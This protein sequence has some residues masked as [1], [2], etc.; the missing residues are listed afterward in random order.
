M[1]GGGY[2]NRLLWCFVV[3]VVV[4]RR[5]DYETELL[6][7]AEGGGEKRN[8][9]G[10]MPANDRPPPKTKL[11]SLEALKDGTGMFAAAVGEFH[12]HEPLRH[13]VRT[14]GTQG[15]SALTEQRCVRPEIEVDVIRLGLLPRHVCCGVGQARFERLFSDVS[16]RYAARRKRQW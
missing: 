13:T 3:V 11:Y 10:G 1:K 6:W 4:G 12:L 2:T 16:F 8:E 5:I 15:H 9:R 7:N 14:M